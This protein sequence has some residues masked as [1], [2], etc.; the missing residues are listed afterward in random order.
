VLQATIEQS[1]MDASWQEVG[2]DF[3]VEAASGIGLEV[4]ADPRSSGWT[5]V[6]AGFVE[7][8]AQLSTSP[9]DLTNILLQGVESAAYDA[10]LA[11]APV[12]PALV[13]RLGHVPTGPGAGTSDDPIPALLSTG[14][15]G[16]IPALAIGDL[17]EVSVRGRTIIM[18]LVD[19]IETFPGIAH[20]TPFVI[21]PFEA[22]AAATA[23][24][25]LR[26]T[27]YFV[28]G[29]A[30]DVERLRA[31]TSSF[32]GATVVSRH[33]RF[34]ALHD[35]PL[36]AAVTG[37]FGLALVVAA[38]YA[39][40]AVLAVVVLQAR[41]RSRELAFLRTLGLTD[42]QLGSLT[43]VEQGLPLILALVIGIGLGLGLAWLLEPGIDLAAFSGPEST[44][45]M[46][47]DWPSIA[48][49]A[50]AIS[51]IVVLAIGS[52]AALARRLDLATALRLGEE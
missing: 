40:L 48:T 21:V 4:G 12:A 50:I 45:I 47:I 43:V 36:V 9:R 32:S 31:V 11:D 23:P 19:R 28:R 39:G 7:P 24:K 29:P 1:Q 26:P 18:R 46:R 13:A 52:S 30:A 37:G 44:A 16:S 34:A 38:G 27:I 41:R 49:V 10:V 20:A 33:E 14:L 5:N 42:R 22:L 6:A 25:S 35:A 2:A 8:D 15:P 51:G 17:F 3:R